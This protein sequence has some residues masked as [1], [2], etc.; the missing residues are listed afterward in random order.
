MCVKVRLVESSTNHISRVHTVSK[1][2]TRFHDFGAPENSK[3]TSFAF[4]LACPTRTSHTHSRH[5]RGILL[6][7][8]YTSMASVRATGTVMRV[9]GLA[10]RRSTCSSVANAQ[11]RNF[12]RT[13]TALSTKKIA[14]KNAVVD[15]DGDEMTRIIW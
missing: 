7:T 1:I 4:V 10:A 5:T 12:T 6:Y 9:G 15:L 2:N 13:A 14:V 3:Y 11:T 8:K